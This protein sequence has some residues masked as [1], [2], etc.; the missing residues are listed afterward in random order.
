LGQ[1][2]SQMNLRDPHRTGTLFLLFRL[3]AAKLSRRNA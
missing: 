3:L 2:A 1:S